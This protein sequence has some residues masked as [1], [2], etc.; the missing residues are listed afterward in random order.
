MDLDRRRKKGEIIIT[1]PDGKIELITKSFDPSKSERRASLVNDE[2]FDNLEEFWDEDSRRESSAGKEES[3]VV[4]E[5][6]TEPKEAPKE[7]FDFTTAHGQKETPSDY[8]DYLAPLEG[9][10][11]TPQKDE[12]QSD[13]SDGFEHTVKR[14]GRKGAAPKKGST[15]SGVFELRQTSEPKRKRVPRL[16]YWE[17]E[18][19]EYEVGQNSPVMRIVRPASTQ[20]EKAPRPKSGIKKKRESISAKVNTDTNPEEATVAVPI[21][22][23]R[24]KKTANYDFLLG[25]ILENTDGSIASKLMVFPAGTEKPEKDVFGNTLLFY[26]LAGS[27]DVTIGGRRFSAGRGY[28]FIVQKYNVYRI[29][30]NEKKRAELLCVSVSLE[31]EE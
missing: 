28:N 5:G 11:S 30:N 12:P 4:V 14:V 3:S 16:K 13:G 20:E 2:V 6:G 17:G 23:V 24:A 19:I 27:V 21:E 10:L 1:H 9:P 31:D 18:R 25:N 8:D 29:R 7:S 15:K 26:V 22:K